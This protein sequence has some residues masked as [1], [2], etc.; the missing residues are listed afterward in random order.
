MKFSDSLKEFRK[1]NNLTQQELADK[2]FVSRSAIAKW[3]QDRGLPSEELLQQIS[4]LMDV[5][6]DQLIDN[7]QLRNTVI[8]NQRKQFLHPLSYNATIESSI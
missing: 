5:P 4:T 7:Q 3:E 1:Q 2:L 6:L 8:K